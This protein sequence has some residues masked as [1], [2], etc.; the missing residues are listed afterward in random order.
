[1]SGRGDVTIPVANVIRDW[2]SGQQKVPAASKF[3]PE[4]RGAIGRVAARN[5]SYRSYAFR[6]LMHLPALLSEEVLS[7]LAA[8]P[9]SGTR[10]RPEVLSA[11]QAEDTI[12]MSIAPAPKELGEEIHRYVSFCWGIPDNDLCSRGN[13]QILCNQFPENKK[14]RAFGTLLPSQTSIPDSLRMYQ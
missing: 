12:G 7:I 4:V 3:S 11:F 10:A 2:Y 8:Q 13:A 14:D 9:N 5:D 1:M 6:P